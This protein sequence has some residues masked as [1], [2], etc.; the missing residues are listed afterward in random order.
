MSGNA[1]WI[2]FKSS[3]F[4]AGPDFFEGAGLSLQADS[5]KYEF[6]HENDTNIDYINVE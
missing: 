6:V 5:I 3:Y 2:R 4:L 1:P